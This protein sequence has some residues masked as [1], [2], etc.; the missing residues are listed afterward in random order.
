VLRQEARRSIEDSSPVSS[1]T[2]GVPA[3]AAKEV[4]PGDGRSSRSSPIAQLVARR[5]S[6]ATAAGV[7][8]L[9]PIHRVYALPLVG[10]RSRSP[11]LIT[12]Q[13]SSPKSVASIYRCKFARG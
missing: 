4:K 6:D 9:L 5:P 2:R 1:V 12:R 8:A 13:V 3:M 11:A 10:G 7:K